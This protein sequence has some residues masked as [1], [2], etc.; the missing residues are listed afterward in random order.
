MLRFHGRKFRTLYSRRSRMYFSFRKKSGLRKKQ[1]VIYDAEKFQ[2]C[3]IEKIEERAAL[4]GMSF[5]ELGRRANL[6]STPIETLKQIRKGRQRL[7]FPHFI[8]IANALDVD[9]SHLIFL[10]EKEYLEKNKAESVAKAAEPPEP[11]N[12]NSHGKLGNALNG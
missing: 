11:Y 3:V 8:L 2:S 10:A 1:D 7:S 6:T 12:G 9:P 4:K 5:S